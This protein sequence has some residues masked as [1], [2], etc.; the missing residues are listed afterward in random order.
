MENIK[1]YR[2]F[3]YEAVKIQEKAGISPAVYSDLKKYFKS[4]KSPSLKGAQKYIS[5]KMKGWDLSEEDY[6]EA[7][8]MFSK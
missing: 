5:D 4:E 1:E 3:I 7:K 8:K 6:N 2:D